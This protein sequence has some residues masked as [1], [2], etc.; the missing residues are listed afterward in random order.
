MSFIRRSQRR[1]VDVL[2]MAMAARIIITLL[3]TV[4]V[5]PALVMLNE[6]FPD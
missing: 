4:A 5:L 6:Y 1:H 2:V 3:A